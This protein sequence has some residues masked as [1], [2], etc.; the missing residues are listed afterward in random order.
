MINEIIGGG[1]RII[2]YAVIA[3]GLAFLLRLLVRVPDEVFRKLL[4]CIALGALIPFVFGFEN[5]YCAVITAIL[6]AVILFPVL[7]L[8]DKIPGFSAFITERKRGELKISMVLFFTMYAIVITVCWGLLKD[9]YLVLASIYAWGFGDAAA[10]LIG[11]RFGKTKI[12]LPHADRKKSI[13]GTNA[14]FFTSLIST[15]VI[16]YFRGGMNTAGYIAVPF[17]TAVVAAL[18]E[19]YTPDGYDTIT[20][21]AAAMAVLIPL[22]RLFGV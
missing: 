19:L 3:A 11:K 4:H 7:T 22:T 2:E 18:A 14:M 15:A 16:L 8:A 5:W 13:A 12:P 9:R 6:L 17:V 21:P 10:A 20:C 1:L